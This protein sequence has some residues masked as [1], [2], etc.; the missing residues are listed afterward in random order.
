M[1]V[2]TVAG[3]LFRRIGW[4]KE[5]QPV[6][7]VFPTAINDDKL[8]PLLNRRVR[9]FLLLLIFLLNCCN[10]TGSVSLLQVTT[11]SW[12]HER[13][14]RRNKEKS[15]GEPKRD[16]VA[17]RHVKY[18]TWKWARNKKKKRFKFK[19]FWDLFKFYRQEEVR[20]WRRHLSANRG[21]QKHWSTE[22]CRVNR[23]KRWMSE[24]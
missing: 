18:G 11:N 22:R 12:Y 5:M 1:C 10:R 7:V 9:F 8:T 3:V 6:V 17:L 16:V 15:S 13:N 23:P 14:T 19:S 4:A 20:R 21:D 2:C 24:Q